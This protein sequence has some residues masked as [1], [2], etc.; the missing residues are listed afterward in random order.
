MRT[1]EYAEA[2]LLVDDCETEFVEGNTVLD[3]RVRTDDRLRFAA[4][5]ISEDFTSFGG[6]KAAGEKRDAVVGVVKKLACVSC[7]LLSKDLGWCH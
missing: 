3:Y 4:F 6:F 7:M 1:L 2:V 5:D